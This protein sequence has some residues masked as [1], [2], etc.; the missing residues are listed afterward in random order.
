M[1]LFKVLYKGS[2]EWVFG[3]NFCSGWTCFCFSAL[4]AHSPFR[5]VLLSFILPLLFQVQTSRAPHFS[6]IFMV[7]TPPNRSPTQSILQLWCFLFSFPQLWW[8]SREKKKK[9]NPTNQNN[10]W[11]D[12]GESSCGCYRPANTAVPSRW[13][14][15][16]TTTSTV[17]SWAFEHYH[18]QRKDLGPMPYQLL[19]A[20]SSD[21]LMLV[22]QYLQKLLHSISK[23]KKSTFK[24]H[25]FMK[26]F[27]QLQ[28]VTFYCDI[29]PMAFFRTPKQNQEESKLDKWNNPFCK[30]NYVRINLQGQ[31]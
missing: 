27:R 24:K 2:L 18:L 11:R 16:S 5:K 31:V 3:T 8:P 10:L 6:H 23:E 14:L 20:W 19:P 26:T 30:S 25:K 28:S 12:E 17:I 1:L 13:F 29:T 21:K 15:L 9:Q 4:Q 7:Q 22:S